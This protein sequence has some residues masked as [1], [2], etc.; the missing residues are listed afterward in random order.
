[1][2]YER[3]TDPGTRRHEVERLQRFVLGALDERVTQKMLQAMDVGYGPR[4]FGRSKQ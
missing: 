2:S 1:M 4:P 3:L